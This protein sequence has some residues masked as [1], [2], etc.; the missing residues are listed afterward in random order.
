[1]DEGRAYAVENLKPVRSDCA[2]RRLPRRQGTGPRA[3]RLYA[4]LRTRTR[5][6]HPPAAPGLRCLSLFLVEHRRKAEPGRDRD[7]GR[8][9]GRAS[10]PFP[11]TGT[12]EA[13]QMSRSMRVPG[14]ASTFL[15]HYFGRGLVDEDRRYAVE[16]FR[17]MSNG[18]IRRWAGEMPAGK[19]GRGRPKP[20]VASIDAVR[21]MRPAYNEIIVCTGLGTRSGVQFW[22]SS[23]CGLWGDRKQRR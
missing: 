3:H 23:A 13:V 22:G 7:G 19:N 12:M 20:E 10:P 5:N 21:D 4:V 11:I 18:E 9:P 16:R 15:T 1:M 8:G 6:R 14:Q 2:R 17:A